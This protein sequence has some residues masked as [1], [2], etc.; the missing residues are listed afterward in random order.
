MKIEK[1]SILLLIN[2]VNECRKNIAVGGHKKSCLDNLLNL[3]QN[4]KYLLLIDST[5]NYR[6]IT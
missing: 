1:G 3:F 5:F 6:R 2:V 4:M